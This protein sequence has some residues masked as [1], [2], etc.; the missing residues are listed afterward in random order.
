MLQDTDRRFTTAVAYSRTVTIHSNCT[1]FSTLSRAEIYTPPRGDKRG[2][3]GPRPSGASRG[4]CAFSY[5]AGVSSPP[6]TELFVPPS[7]LLSSSPSSA[8]SAASPFHPFSCCDDFFRNF[9]A[10]RPEFTKF[11]RRQCVAAMAGGH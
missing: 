5:G 3:R 8:F 9:S 10:F 4:V 6:S 11:G 2:P 7:P 1:Y